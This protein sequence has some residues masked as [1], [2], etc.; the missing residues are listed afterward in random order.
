[1][2]EPR[3][4]TTGDISPLKRAFIALEETRARLLGEAERVVRD[5]FGGAVTRVV[6]CSAF[7][8]RR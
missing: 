4:N 3:N 7:V 5:T 1:M 6:T 2:T 8:G